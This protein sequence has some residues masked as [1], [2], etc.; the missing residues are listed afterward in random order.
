MKRCLGCLFLL[1]KSQRLP[2][3]CQATSH[4]SSSVLSRPRKLVLGLV[5]RLNLF[6]LLIFK[7]VETQ[8]TVAKNSIPIGPLSHFSLVLTSKCFSW[9]VSKGKS[10]PREVKEAAQCHT[11]MMGCEC[12]SGC[13]FACGTS[14]ACQC[15]QLKGLK[16]SSRGLSLS[17]V[18]SRAV[19]VCRR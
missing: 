2:S 15:E 12:E 11:A 13:S 14:A 19:G 10:R 18:R 6:L 7:S 8:K 9:T 3:S 4:L 17:E 5:L 1:H 16:R